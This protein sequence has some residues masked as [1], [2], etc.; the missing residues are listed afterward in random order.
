MQLSF[1]DFSRWDTGNWVVFGIVVAALLAYW[2]WPQAEEPDAEVGVSES[3]RKQ[4]KSLVALADEQAP[5]GLFLLEPMPLRIREAN[6]PADLPPADVREGLWL[7]QRDLIQRLQSELDYAQQADVSENFAIAAPANQPASLLATTLTDLEKT[8]IQLKA[9]WSLPDRM[10]RWRGRALMLLL[11]NRK[12]FDHVAWLTAAGSGPSAPG[13][14]TLISDGTVLMPIY[15][16]R[17][18]GFGRAST[19]QVARAILRRLPT[20]LPKWFEEGLAGWSADMLAGAANQGELQLASA[21]EILDP[22]KWQGAHD[23]SLLYEKLLNASY[24]SV[25]ML[26][27]KKQDALMAYL[28]DLIAGAPE[29]AAFEKH[30]GE[31]LA[32]ALERNIAAARAEEEQKRIE[33]EARAKAEREKMEQRLRR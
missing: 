33:A 14:F 13:A 2:F 17:L 8:V 30:L 24:R 1:L 29:V 12:L 7:V 28:A 4:A 16:T 9:L 32:V 5:T 20:A 22:G 21:A 11:S 26:A 25:A 10:G 6:L 18:G 23:D 3:T 15:A 27:Q 31:P 19:L